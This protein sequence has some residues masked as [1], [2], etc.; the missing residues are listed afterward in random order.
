MKKVYFIALLLA[1]TFPC[2]AVENISS[3]NKQHILSVE[4]GSSTIDT[5]LPSE[6]SDRVETYSLSYG[7]QY[8]SIWV[9]NTE[10]VVGKGDDCLLVCAGDGSNYNFRSSRYNGYIINTKGSLPLSSRWSI[11]GQLGVN[12]WQSELYGGQ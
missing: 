6:E 10:L 4:H 2:L 8:D 11:F 12:Y 1:L 7:D 5:D 9:I 3:H